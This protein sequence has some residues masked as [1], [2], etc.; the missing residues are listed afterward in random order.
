YVSRRCAGGECEKTDTIYKGRKKR[1]TPKEPPTKECSG[2]GD[3]HYSTFDGLKYDFQG[4][5]T[6]TLVEDTTFLNTFK[7]HVKNHH[8]NSATSV[9]KYVE[10][11]LPEKPNVWTIIRFEQ[12]GHGKN[13]IIVDGDPVEDRPYVQ[14]GW[15]SADFSGNRFT[16]ESKPFSLIVRFNVYPYSSRPHNPGYGNVW[17]ELGSQW[18]GK[19]DGLCKNYDNDTKN[20]WTDKEGTDLTGN[21]DRGTLLGT[22]YK[23][24]NQEDR[25]CGNMIRDRIAAGPRGRKIKRPFLPPPPIPEALK[26]C[27][28]IIS[29]NGFFKQIVNNHERSDF[30]TWESDCKMDYSAEPKAKCDILETFVVTFRNNARDI[31]GWREN[32]N[33]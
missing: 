17:I 7:V 15:F 8:W 12:D 18:M 25:V 27:S 16:F 2:T 21:P 19:V 1:Q 20:D 29:Q 3:V 33:C 11:H 4:I 24:D 32:F 13:E 5:C 22:S 26:F 6:Y 14:N 30:D 28:S 9:T 23:V 10:I 31:M